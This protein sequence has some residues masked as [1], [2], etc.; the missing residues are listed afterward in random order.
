MAEQ[1]G[2]GHLIAILHVQVGELRDA[3]DPAI[4]AAVARGGHAVGAAA[5]SQVLAMTDEELGAW[6]R[7]LVQ[8]A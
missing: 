6:V 3:I 5:R 4:I 2:D 7:G 8:A 1:L